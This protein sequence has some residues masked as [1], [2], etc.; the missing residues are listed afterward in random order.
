METYE[1]IIPTIKYFSVN[2][3]KKTHQSNYIPPLT[4][5]L[6][7]TFL[8][9][10]D[11]V[12]N[13]NQITVISNSWEKWRKY[14]SDGWTELK[15]QFASSSKWPW[16]YKNWNEKIDKILSISIQGTGILYWYRNLTMNIR[17]KRNLNWS[18]WHGKYIGYQHQGMLNRFTN[19]MSNTGAYLSNFYLAR[20]VIMNFSFLFKENL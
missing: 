2:L 11:N 7:H 4:Q 13:I 8:I 3:K 6:Q 10:R 9:L 5:K 16:R 15:Q 14:V 19:K 1:A 17:L 12:Q 18:D 20:S